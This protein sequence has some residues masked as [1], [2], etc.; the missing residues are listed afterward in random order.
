LRRAATNRAPFL[1]GWA[2]E[3]PGGQRHLARRF[4][5]LPMVEEKLRGLRWKP[6]LRQI[7]SRPALRSRMGKGGAGDGRPSYPWGEGADPNRAN[8]GETGL[9]RTNAVGCFLGGVSPYGCEEMSGNVWE[10]TRSAWEGGG[11]DL[12]A[13]SQALRVLRGGSFH[14]G[15]RASAVPPATGATHTTARLHRIPGRSAPFRSDL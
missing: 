13:P 2:R 9:L 7:P 4:R 11:D 6:S 3:S 8:F 14:D 12:E 15:S 1:P 10:W 5:V